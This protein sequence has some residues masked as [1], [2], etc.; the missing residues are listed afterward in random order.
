MRTRYNSTDRAV[1]TTLAYADIFDFPLTVGEIV[2]Y[3]IGKNVTEKS[4][5]KSLSYLLGVRADEH[6][7]VT[8]AKRN[9]T[10]GIRRI[11][12]RES[13][14]KW[15]VVSDVARWLRYVPTITLVG[16]TGALAMGNAGHGDDIDLFIVVRRHTLWITRALTVFLVEV[17]GNRRHPEQKDVSNSICL[18]MFVSEDGLSLTS[19]EHN[20]YTAHEV[21][22]M[23]PVW[24]RETTYKRFL[25]ANRWVRP[26]VPNWWKEKHTALSARQKTGDTDTVT[27][28][29]VFLTVLLFPFR[30]IEPVAKQIQ[31]SYMQKRRTSEVIGDSAVR[32]HPR[33]T[34]GFVY[35]ELSKRMSALN[36]PLDNV[37]VM[38]IK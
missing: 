35:E 4:V 20:L 12:A 38:S 22:Q 7:F 36:I 28:P 19:A 18:N 26:Y 25:E 1:V 15:R 37:F 9:H 16:A 6:T 10:V 34:K 24:E 3:C 11:R 33:D 17:L 32:F 14:L 23:V 27:V 30:L 21:M 29:E 31:L 5:R 13:F 2:R 8:L